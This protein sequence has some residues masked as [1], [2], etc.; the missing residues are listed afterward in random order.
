M[1]PVWSTIEAYAEQLERLFCQHAGATMDVAAGQR[2]PALSLTLPLVEP[3]RRV[4][5][6]MEG[7]EVRYFL[8]DGNDLSWVRTHET[9][10]DRAVYLLLA[11][12]AANG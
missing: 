2:G 6:V 7:N 12:L 4:C 8:A 5:V 3:E 11:E 1:H 10:V 9:R